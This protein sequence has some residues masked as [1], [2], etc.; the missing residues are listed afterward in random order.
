LSVGIGIDPHKRTVAAAT[1][2]D[3][4]RPRHMREFRNDPEGHEALWGWVLGQGEDRTIGIECSGT[5]GAALARFLLA[6]GEDVREVSGLLVNRERGGTPAAGKSDTVDALAAA[7]VVVREPELPGV[8]LDPIAEELEL[9]TA[10]RDQLKCARNQAQNR[11]HAHLVVARAG[12]QDKVPRLTR[13]KHLAAAVCL[14]RGDH[15]LRAEIVRDLIAEIRRL[16]V[17][18]ADVDRRIRA[19]LKRSGTSLTKEYGVGSITAAKI[20]GEIGD[21]TQ[22]RSECAFAMFDGTAPVEASSGPTK[23]HRLNRGGNR[24]LNYALHMIAITRRRG[25][26][27]S[28]AYVARK[29]ASGKTDKEA[30]RCLKRQISNRIYRVLMADARGGQIAA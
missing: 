2:D 24:Q 8:R 18:M 27:E 7:R 5:Y 10:R 11:A 4:G 15:S 17:K 12:Y 29:I 23:R 19:A 13:K 22:F 6:R 9:F 16:D 3:V 28:Q 26:A 1:V 14:I 25:H 30:L 21:V 20:L